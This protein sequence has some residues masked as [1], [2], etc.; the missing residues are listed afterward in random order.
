MEFPADEP[1]LLGNVLFHSFPPVH[2]FRFFAP[3]TVNTLMS[4]T[5]ITHLPDVANQ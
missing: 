1:R 4:V 3:G 5:A 2:E